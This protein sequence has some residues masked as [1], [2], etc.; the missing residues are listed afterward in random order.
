MKHVLRIIRNTLNIPQV[1]APDI[2]GIPQRTLT[3]LESGHRK[4][5]SLETAQKVSRATGV[6]V[7]S[8]LE[9]SQN[10]V[11]IDGRIFEMKTYE[12]HKNAQKLEPLS[13]AELLHFYF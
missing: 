3:A 13:A 9:N 12:E 4:N 10:P 2:L 5:M 6:A 1:M 7:N 11:T 8:L